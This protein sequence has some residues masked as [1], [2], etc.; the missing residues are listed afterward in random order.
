MTGRGL[1]GLC[2]F[3]SGM[4]KECYKSFLAVKYLALGK[5]TGLSLSLCVRTC[6]L[7]SVHTQGVCRSH[8]YEVPYIFGR[9]NY[10]VQMLE[11]S[12]FFPLQFR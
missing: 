11:I 4:T 9:N 12:L 3:S 5:E 2:P 6:A 1:D 8:N 7:A 10:E